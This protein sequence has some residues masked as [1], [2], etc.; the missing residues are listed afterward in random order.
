MRSGQ[1]L[2]LILLVMVVVLAIG[3]SV[4]SRNI[5]NLRTAT[6]TEQSQRAFSAAE[7][8][9]ESVL[10]QIPTLTLNQQNLD[11]IVKSG[12]KFDLNKLGIRSDVAGS[13][14]LTGSKTFESTITLGNIGQIDLGNASV[15]HQVRIDWAKEGEN[16]EDTWP[17]SLEFNQVFG[18]APAYDQKRVYAQGDSGRTNERVTGLDM[19]QTCVPRDNFRK[20]AQITTEAGALILRIKPFWVDT[21]VK[22]SGVSPFDLPV[23]SYNVVSTATTN[24][25]VT[26]KVEVVK[27]VL[28]ILPA[29][30]D[31]VLYSG[32]NVV[33]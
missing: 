24:I 29:V 6:Q 10:S 14:S 30:F 19:A 1:I 25:G 18:S 12:K 22:V 20:C 2:I 11:Q 16:A 27:T 28:P 32:S 26:R 21:T 33:K 3:L 31:Y 15:G 4:A 7:G 23:Q 5:T 13:V 9:V 17:A 8:G